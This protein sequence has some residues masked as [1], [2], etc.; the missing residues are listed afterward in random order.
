MQG[1][2]CP[3]LLVLSLSLRLHSFA[4]HSTSYI[5]PGRWDQSAVPP[6]AYCGSR[7]CMSRSWQ[8]CRGSRCTQPP[9]TASSPTHQLLPAS[10]ASRTCLPRAS[11]AWWWGPHSAGASLPSRPST[12][13]APPAELHTAGNSNQP[14]AAGVTYIVAPAVSQLLTW[15]AAVA[16]IQVKTMGVS[17]GWDL[18]HTIQGSHSNCSS[19]SP[20]STPRS[21][22]ST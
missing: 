18:C 9:L 13:A 12:S 6:L 21:H 2:S 15:A 11:I 8:W 3:R 1:A 19:T 22:M 14:Q 5:V 16:R 10:W 7:S 17:I 20:T 4:S